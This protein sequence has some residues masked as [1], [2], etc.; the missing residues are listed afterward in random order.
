M[1]PREEVVRVS[2]KLRWRSPPGPADWQVSGVRQDN[3]WKG[4]A[5]TKKYQRTGPDT[6]AL[7]VPEQVR[8]AL[9]E[10]AADM[11]DGLLA[12]AVGAGRQVMTQ[13]GSHRVRR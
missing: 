13:R 12:L 7:A 6:S 8:V 1:P 11:R 9:A 2:G 10:I 4:T 5:V 3:P